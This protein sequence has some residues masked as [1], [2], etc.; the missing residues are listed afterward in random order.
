MAGKP[1]ELQFITR[2]VV[3]GV[4]WSAR[5]G[6]PPFVGLSGDEP[7]SWDKVG[8]AL[9]GDFRV[10]AVNPESPY[11]LLNVIW[12]TREPAIVVA[13]GRKACATAARTA[14]QGAGSVRALVL[15]EFGSARSGGWL[16]EVAVPTLVL[17]GRQSK[18]QTHE[19]AVAIHE[20]IRRSRLIEP[21]DCGSKPVQRYTN[22]LLQAVRWYLGSL[23]AAPIDFPVNGEPIDPKRG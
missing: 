15:I 22:V 4:E 1:V 6:A 8:E 12:A 23:G 9:A 7:A 16:R 21:E 3:N 5:D 20:L 14:I 17:R 2:R 11:D 18:V 19:D 13:Q 10:I